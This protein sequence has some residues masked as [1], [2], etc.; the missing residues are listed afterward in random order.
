MNINLFIAKNLFILITTIIIIHSPNISF[1]VKMIS[2]ILTI[3][4]FSNFIKTNKKENL[5]SYHNIGKVTIDM[6]K[7]N[8]NNILTY[9]T[10]GTIKKDI[11]KKNLEIYKSNADIIDEEYD[12]N[13]ND[14]DLIGEEEDNLEIINY[15]MDDL[16]D[17]IMTKLD[18][19]IATSKNLNDF[20]NTFEQNNE[21]RDYNRKLAAYV[22]SEY[23]SDLNNVKNTTIP[24]NEDEMNSSY[25]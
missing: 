11:R 4:V 13:I 12:Y 25:T 15:K 19:A 24:I 8:E 16:K 7:N 21:N 1:S 18:H 20:E 3:C 5:Q 23:E 22:D 6:L 2:T 9:E 10:K 14:E 17:E